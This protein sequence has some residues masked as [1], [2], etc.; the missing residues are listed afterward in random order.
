LQLMNEYLAEK[1]SHDFYMPFYW[2]RERRM[3][4]ELNDLVNR[5][6]T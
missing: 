3:Q 4:R 5:N 6:M 1:S 2:R